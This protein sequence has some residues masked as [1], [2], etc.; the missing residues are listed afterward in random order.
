[1]NLEEK[2]KINNEENSVKRTFNARF[3]LRYFIDCMFI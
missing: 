1:M 3:F 2:K